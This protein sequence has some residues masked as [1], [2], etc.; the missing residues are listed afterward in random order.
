MNI[1]GF[2][3]RAFVLTFSRRLSCCVSCTRN[4]RG[5]VN[6]D[7]LVRKLR[8]HKRSEEIAK[9]DELYKRA[10]PLADKFMKLR[11]KVYV[12]TDSSS[13]IDETFREA[14]IKYSDIRVLLDCTTELLS[15]A[16]GLDIDS[17]L[18]PETHRDVVALLN[19]IKVPWEEEARGTS[20]DDS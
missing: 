3:M 20:F 2:S 7:Q 5:T 14:G 13:D 6:I 17:N 8:K 1:I 19:K 4:K 12:H 16:T 11:H 10:R 15:A 9:P 18:R